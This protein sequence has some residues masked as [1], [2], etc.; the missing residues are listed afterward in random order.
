MQVE[1]LDV[2]VLAAAYS[3]TL[4]NIPT[5]FQ[6]RGRVKFWSWICNIQHVYLRSCVGFKLHDVCNISWL[7]PGLGYLP[8]NCGE[9]PLFTWNIVMKSYVLELCPFR[10]CAP[11]IHQVRAAAKTEARFATWWECFGY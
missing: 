5:P 9:S 6:S 4:N 3:L 7:F 2:T 10:H 8:L 1:V 11:S